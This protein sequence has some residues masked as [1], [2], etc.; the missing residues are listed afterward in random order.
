MVLDCL[1]GDDT[2]LWLYLEPLTLHTRKPWGSVWLERSS[3]PV[4]V[5]PKVT[6][7]ILPPVWWRKKDGLLTLLH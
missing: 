3:T 1:C 2:G 5:K 6:Q 7:D 4:L